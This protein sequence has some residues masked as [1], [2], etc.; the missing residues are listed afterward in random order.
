MVLVRS[1]SQLATII[2]ARMIQ[3]PGACRDPA[4]FRIFRSSSASAGGRAYNN[5]GTTDRLPASMAPQ[6]TIYT[7][8][9]KLRIRDPNKVGI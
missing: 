6:Q 7:R 3:S 9:E 1:P 5:F 8:K 2:F 4:N